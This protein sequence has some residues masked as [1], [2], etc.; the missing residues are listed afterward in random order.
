MQDQPG[1]GLPTTNR[2]S[3]EDA[4]PVC[5]EELGLKLAF[6]RFSPDFRCFPLCCTFRLP[7]V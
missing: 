1:S 5:N 6:A 3:S 4:S 2:R 7:K